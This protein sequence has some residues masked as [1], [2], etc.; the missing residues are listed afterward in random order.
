MFTKLIFNF[1]AVL[2]TGITN[3]LFTFSVTKWLTNLARGEN[4]I[5]AKPGGA[6]NA[7]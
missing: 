1:H 5:G 7:F 3:L 2:S 4:D 6:L